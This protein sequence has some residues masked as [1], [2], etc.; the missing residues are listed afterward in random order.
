M[1]TLTRAQVDLEA[2]AIR[3]DPGMTKNDDG[4]TVYMTP[5]LRRLVAAQ[6]DRV[7]TLEREMGRIIPYLFPHFG[8]QFE[9]KRRSD[10]R[11]AWQNAC[12]KTGVSGRLRHDLRRTAVRNLVNAGV[13]ERVAMSITGHKTRA[14]FDRYHI[15]SPT[16]LKAAAQKLAGTSTGTI[17]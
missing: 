11:E 3:L 1:L 14:V 9:G 12:R 16:D 10:Y 5:D 13:A 4:R 7:H 2:G 6:I 15:V 17:G 8:K